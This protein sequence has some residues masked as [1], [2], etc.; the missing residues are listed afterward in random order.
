VFT[1]L[2][3]V[4]DL[5]LVQDYV[6]LLCKIYQHSVY[7]KLSSL[8]FTSKLPLRVSQGTVVTFYRC[9]GQSN[10]RSFPIFFRI[11]YTKKIVKIGSFLTELLKIK[12]LSIAL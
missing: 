3:N 1:K 11:L 5:T 6:P 9:G 8:L 10:K 2:I 12:M 4:L 7:Q